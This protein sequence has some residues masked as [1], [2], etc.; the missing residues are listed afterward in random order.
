MSILC[1]DPKHPCQNL[2]DTHKGA[3]VIPFNPNTN[4]ILLGYEL[5]GQYVNTFNF[6]AGGQE[7]KDED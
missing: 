1:T 3:A 5:Y 4:D 2:R 7:E 6:F